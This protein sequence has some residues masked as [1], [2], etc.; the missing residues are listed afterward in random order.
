MTEELKIQSY[1]GVYSVRFS[2]EFSVDL[3]AE[4]KDTDVLFVD[5]N[6]ARLH[7][8]RIDPLL[9]R[10]RHQLIHP[11]ES[12]KSY[13]GVQCYIE[14]LIEGN[15]R[16][17]HRIVAIGGGIVQDITAFIASILYRGV[18]WIF[19]PTNLLSQAD[20]CIGSKTSI[21]FGSFKNQI[22]GFYPP[23]LIIND[24]SFLSSLSE[25]E[26]RSGMGEMLHYFLISGR[27]DFDFVRD[28]YDRAFVDVD[29][30][31]QLVA[32][33]LAIK[34]AMI[35]EDEFDSGP[36]NIFNYG[37]SFGHAIESYTDYAV[38][39]GIAVSFGMDL[40]NH[41]S[42][43]LGFISRD[44]CQEMGSVLK[45]NWVS[46]ALPAIDLDRYIDILR[47][48]KKNFDQQIRV[49]L[50]RGLG[51]MFIASVDLNERLRQVMARCFTMFNSATKPL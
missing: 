16:K 41:L 22:G 17:N 38:P 8:N 23:T 34:K 1:R 14:W 4:L 10:F 15:F 19:V 2:S 21:N 27:S 36:R 44:E 3:L 37:H 33:S 20:S 40:A 39:H 43:A 45:R 51:N 47:K 13:H 5:A 25:R 31:K 12:K 26:I 48:D 32:R 28:N 46:T 49:I 50:T 18:S 6:V 9:K 29:T 11:S 35:E 30:M 24:I 7:A 42:E